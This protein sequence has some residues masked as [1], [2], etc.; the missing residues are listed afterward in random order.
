MLAGPARCLR[1]RARKGGYRQHGRQHLPALE[2]GRE[3]AKRMNLA[4][5]S[6]ELRAQWAL[7]VRA[8]R[9]IFAYTPA[10]ALSLVTVAIGYAVP[11]LVWRHIYL[12]RGASIAMPA[13][14]L[15]PYLL[16]AATL[17][18]CSFMGVE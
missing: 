12:A 10:L 15:F 9:T 17:N 6:G 4:A 2:W 5:W 14:Q 8:A 7:F 1:H 11:M 13:S 18:F 3:R 16:L